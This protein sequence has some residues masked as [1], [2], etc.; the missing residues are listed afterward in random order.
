VIRLSIKRLK[1]V[2]KAQAKNDLEEYYN[3]LADDAEDGIQRNNLRPAYDAIKR[4]TIGTHHHAFSLSTIH[5]K[6]GSPC[7]SVEES[8]ER[9]TEHYKDMLNHS[10][11]DACPALDEAATG[12]V[13]DAESFSD[14][15]TLLEVTKAIRKLRNSKAAGPDNIQPELL[16]YDE[17][18]VAQTLHALFHKVWSMGR[19]PADW[20]EGLIIS[21]YKGKGQKTNCSSYR[22]ISLLLVPGKVLAHVLLG[23]LQPLLV[24]QRHSHQSGFTPGRSSADAILTLQLLA[25]IH[26]EF[27]KPLHTTFIDIKSAFDSVDRDALWKA[28]AAKKAPPFLIRLI[29]DLHRLTT[30]RVRIGNKLSNSFLTSSGVRQGCILAPMLF[31]LATDWIMSQCSSALGTE[32]GQW[33]FTDQIYADDAALFTSDATNWPSLLKMFDSAAATMGLHASWTKTRVQNLGCGPSASPADVG[34][35]QVE[36]VNR[37][38]YLGSDL[39]SSGYCSP[40]IL[41]RIGIASS[42]VGRLDNIWKQPHLSLQTKLRIYTSCV[43]STLLHGADTWTILKA[44]GK[45]LQAFHM[46]CQRRILGIRWSDFVTN[47]TVA[48]KTV[49]QTS[50]Q[51]LATGGSFLTR[52]TSVRG[53]TSALCPPSIC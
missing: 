49:F 28:L 3:R 52:Q 13:P 21:L 5:K 48:E 10:P 29:Q 6:D 32:V 39:D 38:T 31:C 12:A 43:Q 2:F 33:K 18:P 44:D 46:Q 4:M 45:R 34:N 40:E 23:R 47:A 36:S 50:R 22:P 27:D 26:H 17:Q 42:V 15:P 35:E 19:V 25:E 7:N 9:W 11:A 24:S 30:A 53:Y 41:H 14:A 51:S 1:G 8:L 16:K 37:F 20:K